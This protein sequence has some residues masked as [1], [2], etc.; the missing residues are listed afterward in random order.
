MTAL[1]KTALL[2]RLKMGHLPD[3]AETSAWLA[4]LRSTPTE[5]WETLAKFGQRAQWDWAFDQGLPLPESQAST[6]LLQTLMQSNAAD[7][8]ERASWWLNHGARLP[9]DPPLAPEPIRASVFTID[10]LWR[11]LVDQRRVDAITWLA[12]QGAPVQ[13][14]REEMGLLVGHAIDKHRV[15][16]VEVVERLIEA[17]ADLG[18]V[19]RDG[20]SALHALARISVPDEAQVEPFRSMWLLLLEG[21]ANPHQANR[22]GET[23]TSLVDPMHKDFVQACLRQVRADQVEHPNR[24]ATRQRRT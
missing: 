10:S 13:F 5:T 24:R 4:V 7:M 3:D 9:K 14:K 1:S 15:H 11:H 12:A 22:A 18:H 6:W 2:N 17:G 19:D 16:G 21:G 8:M 23:P 20:E